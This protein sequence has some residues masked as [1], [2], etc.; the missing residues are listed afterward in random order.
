MTRLYSQYRIYPAAKPVT[1]LLVTATALVCLM[2]AAPVPVHGQTGFSQQRLEEVVVTARKREE[3]SF[4]I[5]ESI[6]VVDSTTFERANLNKMTDIGNLIPNLNLS[7]RGDGTPNVTIRGVGAFGNTRGVGFYVDDVEIFDD[8]A[9]RWGDIE[10]VEVLKGPQGTLYGGSNIGGA[11]KWVTKRPDPTTFSGRIT[12]EFGSHATVD[13]EGALNVPLGGSWAA[14]VFAYF[15]ADDGFLVN[16]SLP[17]VTGAVNRVDP[18]IG[19]QDEQGATLSFAGNLTD[20]LSVYMSG[21]WTDITGPRNEGLEEEDD[22]FEFPK[23][24][25]KTFN[26]EHNIETFS[27]RIQLDYELGFATVTSL[28]SYTESDTFGNSDVD[29]SQEL[30]VEVPS[31]ENAETFT[32]E[33]RI[34]STSDGPLEWLGGLYFLNRDFFRDFELNIFCIQIPF[35]VPCGQ[36]MVV[37]GINIVNFPQTPEDEHFSVTLPFEQRD[38]ETKRYAAFGNLNYRYGPVEFEAGIRVERWERETRH[39]AVN[40]PDASLGTGKAEATEVLPKGSVSYYFDDDRSMIYASFARGF[41]PGGFNLVNFTGSNELFGFGVEEADTIEAGYKG[42]LFDN[43][44]QVSLAAFY[45]ENRDRQFEDIGADPVNGQPIEGIVN[46]GDSEQYGLEGELTW[47]INESLDL[48]LSGSFLESEWQDGTI[49]S[50]GTGQQVVPGADISGLTPPFV[51]DFNF[52]STANYETGLPPLP[53][54][55]NLVFWSRAQLAING[56]QQTNL[57]NTTKNPTHTIVN[58]DAG[59]RSADDRWEVAVH[60]ENLFDKKYFTDIRPFANFNPVNP[61]PG[62]FFG[63]RGQPRWVTVSLGVRF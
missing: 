52:V 44:V 41:E 14:R 6:S 17:R 13:V 10:R 18:D 63:H 28:T 43:K 33:L 50:V 16:P 22:D 11:V 54:G 59:I 56:E 60:I 39:F 53:F 57:L 7:E 34:T 49:L 42:R 26:P 51:N 9:A 31:P 2:V 4:E 8:V 29:Q 38:Q 37:N 30:A 36:P 27:G 23:I 5:P 1:G 40:N 20:R 15:T 32:Q 55:T 35:P 61:A 46:I 45:I 21:R 58:L 48:T 3:T 25:P 19:Q 47:F 12:G 62:I 24:R